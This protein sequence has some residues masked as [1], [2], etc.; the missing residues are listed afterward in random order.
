MLLCR[1]FKWPIGM[2]VRPA[3]AK[4][5]RPAKLLHETAPNDFH[6]MK[7]DYSFQRSHA[8]A[9][10]ILAQYAS[11]DPERLYKPLGL[12]LYTCPDF[13]DLKG[14]Y[15]WVEDRPC[16]FIKADLPR[17]HR[18]LILAHELGHH[19]LHQDLLA[20]LKILQDHSFMDMASQP[21]IEANL[22]AADLL[23]PDQDFLDLAEAG[24]SLDQ[25]AV[26]FGQPVGLVQAKASLL[27][28]QGIPL[29][30][31]ERA[32]ADFLLRV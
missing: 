17:S 10:E 29:R 12:S 1:L 30:L 2:A 24:S 14:M 7:W 22:F 20:G 21:E 9:Q 31:P 4:A 5:V 16:V 13:Q 26:F 23:I 27:H 18:D 15:V 28:W 19:L 25:L 8:A 32:A 6:A 11:R 3:E